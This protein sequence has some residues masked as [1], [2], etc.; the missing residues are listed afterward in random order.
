[1]KVFIKKE[2]ALELLRTNKEQHIKDY[3][4][5]IEDW[6]QAV[7]L[8]QEN[9]NKWITNGAKKGEE[10][11]RYTPDK[12]LDYTKQYDK[13]IMK[14]ELTEGDIIELNEGDQKV[15]IHDEF[16]WKNGFLAYGTTM[17]NMANNV[18]E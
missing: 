11:Q 1:M 14:F 12:P 4:E 10:P 3:A 8:Q 17:K 2:K 15:V 16:D 5:Q 9:Y 18:Y 7:Q 13:W 6:K